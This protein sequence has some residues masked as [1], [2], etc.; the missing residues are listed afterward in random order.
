M[1]NYLCHSCEPN[2]RFRIGSDLAAGLIAVRDIEANESINFDYDVTEDDLRGDRGGFECHCGAP[3]CRK[4][5]LGRL[6]SPRA[7]G[8]ASAPEGA[9]ASVRQEGGGG[10]EGQGRRAA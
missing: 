2:C 8:A 10:P 4:H 7:D 1:D 9:S 6:Y 3:S 5:I